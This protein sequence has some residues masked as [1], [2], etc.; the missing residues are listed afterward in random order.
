MI[1]RLSVSLWCRPCVKLQ[2]DLVCLGS[3]GNVLVYLFI[4][5]YLLY[6]IFLISATYINMNQ[7]QVCRCSLPHDPPSHLPPHPIPLGR[8]RDLG[9]ATCVTQQIPTGYFTYGNVYV[10]TL[11]SQLSHSL[12][13]I[14]CPQVCLLCLHLHCC[15]EKKV[16]QH[17]LSRFHT[18]VSMA[19][20]IFLFMT[21][22]TLY[23]RLY[24]YPPH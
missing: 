5:R 24:V 10:S 11:L 21:Y 2:E 6:H 7:P 14:L 8:H 22:F 12:P 19:I 23:S 20:F 1:E 9:W 13:P 16:Y 18:H 4:A 15:P 3:Q 17:H